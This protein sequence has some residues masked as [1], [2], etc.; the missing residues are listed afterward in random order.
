MPNQIQ[1]F[2]IFMYIF[3]QLQLFSTTL[4]LHREQF[5]GIGREYKE[6]DKH[7]NLISKD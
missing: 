1:T 3:L 6:E 2:S 5:L 4:Q 7:L